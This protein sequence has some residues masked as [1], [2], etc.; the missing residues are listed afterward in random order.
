[1][2]ATE[3]LGVITQIGFVLI[4]ALTLI[5]FLRSPTQ[6]RLNVVLLFGAFAAIVLIQWLLSYG[7]IEQPWL[8]RLMGVLLVAHPYLLLRVVRHLRPGP[9]GIQWWG[10]AG[11]LLS[12]LLLLF[13]PTPMPILV[14]IP[15]VLYFIAGDGYSAYALIDG[16]RKTIGV[17]QRRLQL[18]AIGAGLIALLILNVGFQLIFPLTTPFLTTINQL[19]GLASVVCFYLAFSTP[20]FLRRVWQLNELDRFLRQI[21]TERTSLHL[22]ETLHALCV[23]AKRAGS[24]DLAVAA[25]WDERERRLQVAA[26]SNG[27]TGQAQFDTGH[28]VYREAWEQRKPVFTELP[29]GAI[30][31]PTGKNTPP[32]MKGAYILPI[33]TQERDWGLLLVFLSRLPLFAQDDL[34]LLSLLCE[35]TATALGYVD[36]LASQEKLI[37]RL[38]RYNERL[39]AVTQIDHKI[40]EARLPEEIAHVALAHLQRIV[41]FDRASVILFNEQNREAHYLA[42]EEPVQLG[43]PEGTVLSIE[44]FS[45][46]E[47]LTEPVFLVSNAAAEQHSPHLIETKRQYGISSLIL[48]PLKLEEQL[49]GAFSL[50]SRQPDAYQ[51]EHQ[52]IALEL[53]RQLAIAIQQARLRQEL[54]RTNAELERRVAERTMQLEQAVRDLKTEVARRQKTSE[55]LDAAQ[56]RLQ[57]LLSSTPA[58]IYSIDTRGTH[59]V[60][61][62]SENVYHQLGYE[63]EVFLNNP[64]FWLSQIHPDDAERVRE[65]L[66]NLPPGDHHALEYRFTNSAGQYIWMRDEFRV[67]CDEQGSPVEI[68]GYWIDINKRREAEESILILNEDLHRRALDL[69]AANRELEAFAYSVSHDLRAPLR[70]IDGFSRVLASNFEAELS[71]EARRYLG[72]ISKNTRE[73]GQLIDDLLSFSRINKQSLNVDTVEPDW[74]VPVILRDLLREN[75]GR[76]IEIVRQP[77]PACKGDYN[78]LKQVFT[79]LLSNAFKFTRTREKARIEI[80]GAVD[81]DEAVYSIKDNGVGFDMKYANKLFGVFQRLH[82]AEE[83]EGTGVGLAIVQRI[84]H[85]HGGRVWAESEPDRGAAFYFTIPRDS[86]SG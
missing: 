23:A 54:Q 14:V 3:V 73:M 49:I 80:N 72:L 59:Q 47:Q 25:R 77:L 34:S 48:V 42:V 45:F 61:F 41:P 66:A 53:S 69:Q 36:M 75:E 17:V 68:V 71:D 57:F 76:E 67:I 7:G 84:I 63:T 56:Q 10:L 2:E 33:A 12:A 62:V 19:L 4:A 16:S 8:G 46:L 29:A 52:V 6:V 58:I 13:S 79:N 21:S 28:P 60:T 32:E 74:F 5:E 38:R 24:G 39:E 78:L 82:L 27:E 65:Y 31:A 83:F 35:Q 26:T 22:E 20:A 81:G 1:M 30:P 70:A 9:P 15:I 51:P 64:D 85:R 18:A 86:A 37:D 44:E 55:A 11:F 40:L 43:L 50:S